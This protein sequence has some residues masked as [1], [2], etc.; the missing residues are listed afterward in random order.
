MKEAGI[1]VIGSRNCSNYGRKICK[2]FT[3]NLVGY[4]LN[5]IS[6]LA[7]GIDTCAH[8]AC[9]NAKG[10]TIAVIPSGFNNIYPEENEKLFNKI[11]KNEGTIV[12]EYPFEFQKTKESCRERNRIM[13]G[14]SIAT[15]VVEAGRISG[16]SITVRHAN[17]EHK[18]VFCIPSSIENSKGIGTNKMIKNKQAKIVTE[19]EDIIEELS[20]FK[21]EKKSDFIFMDTKRGSNKI[22]KKKNNFKIDNENLEIYNLL[23]KG[24]RTIDEIVR[25]LNKPIDEVTYKLT[26]L[27]LQNVILKLPGNKFKKIL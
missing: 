17:E 23:E 25:I 18:K 26:L 19:V 14:I 10:K 9:I 2:I 6:G 27:E 5:I 11:L 24:P 21:L 8:K 1:A 16:T 22:N 12:T 7:I 4:N 3:N 20:E 13:S 15:L